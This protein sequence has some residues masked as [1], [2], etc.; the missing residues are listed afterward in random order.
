MHKIINVKRKL[1]REIGVMLYYLD[2]TKLSHASLHELQTDWK[3]SKP[4]LKQSISFSSRSFHI[5]PPHLCLILHL[6]L[7]INFN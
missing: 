1:L 2:H 3:R 7:D 5:L 4:T 6:A